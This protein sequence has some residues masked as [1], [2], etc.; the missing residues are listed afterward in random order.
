MP[1]NTE[2][3]NASS[4][5]DTIRATL[6][7]INER[8]RR[9]YLARGT[10]DF[11]PVDYT[12][13]DSGTLAPDDSVDPQTMSQQT[14]A[15]TFQPDSPQL[16]PQLAPDTYSSAIGQP[17]PAALARALMAY[18]PPP[19]PL[20]DLRPYLM[21]DRGSPPPFPVERFQPSSQALARGL[22]VY[23]PTQQITTGQS[24]ESGIPATRTDESIVLTSAR[25]PSGIVDGPFLGN[26]VPC[27]NPVD[28]P[29]HSY[30]WRT[31]R[32]PGDCS[33]QTMHELLHNPAPG[34]ELNTP[35]QSGDTNI[36]RLG[37]RVLGPIVTAV[38][39]DNN[40]IWNLTMPGHDLHPGWVKRQVI[41]DG[42][43]TWMENTGGGSGDFAT[44]NSCLAPIVWGGE[45]PLKRPPRPMSP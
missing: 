31:Y 17:S 24:D 26:P 21:Q 10:H 14:P 27:T 16:T 18:T 2:N 40:A 22:M 28:L 8:N 6:R 20:E 30:A 44:L 13:D 37:P 3:R 41:V 42:S 1:E 19:D 15:G 33:A 35:V 9:K 43:A 5:E 45:T 29:G 38:D 39:P 36:V 34:V 25:N 23:G 4:L 7:A 12:F 32:C 11:A